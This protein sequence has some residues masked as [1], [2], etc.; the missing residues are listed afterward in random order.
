MGWRGKRMSKAGLVNIFVRDC[1]LD[2]GGGDGPLQF[3]FDSE[4]EAME[5]HWKHVVAVVEAIRAYEKAFE[6]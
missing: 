4:S 5:L 1:I 6:T 3:S 2:V